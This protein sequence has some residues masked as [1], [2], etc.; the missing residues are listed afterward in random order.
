MTLDH[1]RLDTY[2][3]EDRIIRGAWRGTDAKGA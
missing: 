3:R 1:D 2:I